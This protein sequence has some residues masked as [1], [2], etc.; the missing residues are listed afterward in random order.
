MSVY[1]FGV[2]R[3]TSTREV[4]ATRE[5]RRD[6]IAR[7]VGGEGCS[8]VY[9]EMPEGWSG[10]YSAPNLGDPFDRL[11]ALEVL[12]AVAAEEGGAA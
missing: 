2:S 6:R 10:W 11:T 5:R 1:H 3:T 8:Y 4:S 7:R 12:A 9:A